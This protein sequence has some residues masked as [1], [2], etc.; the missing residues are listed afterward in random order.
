MFHNSKLIFLL[1]VGLVAVSMP[2]HASWPGQNGRIVFLAGNGFTPNIFSMADDGS[3]VRQIT[4]FDGVGLCCEALSPDARQIVFTEFPDNA[5]PQIWMVNADGSNLHQVLDDPDAGDQN[6]SFS[7]DGNL[8]YFSRCQDTCAIFRVRTDGSQLTQMNPYLP[9]VFDDVP[10]V[11]PDGRT[12][13][14]D[15]FNRDGV[16]AA[17]YL[18]N[19]DGSNLHRLTPPGIQGID[20]D[21]SPDGKTLTFSAHC[22]DPSNPEI[23]TIRANGTGLKP[24]THPQGNVDLRPAYSPRG[25][26]VVFYRFFPQQN[27]SA[28]YVVDVDSRQER[29]IREMPAPVISSG[30]PIPRA[31]GIHENGRSP[32]A[33]R[34]LRLIRYDAFL[35]KWGVST[36]R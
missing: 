20:G 35:P 25:D 9:N 31:F 8:L 27:V 19:S 16:T 30:E 14:F 17:L 3:D 15:S 10:V 34:D 21:W 5:P 7:P 1:M 23:W 33:E 29:V 22:C 12:I 36:K 2:A 11:S 26:A 6:P 32:I 18:M 24:L 4:F 28:I 13:A